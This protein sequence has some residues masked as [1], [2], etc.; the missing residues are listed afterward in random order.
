VQNLTWGGGRSGCALSGSRQVAR[1][2]GYLFSEIFKSM[3]FAMTAPFAPTRHAPNLWHPLG[4]S[5]DRGRA[6][7]PSI[8]TGRMANHVQNY[9]TDRPAP[10]RRAARFGRA[11]S[12]SAARIYSSPPAPGWLPPDGEGS[13]LPRVTA[14]ICTALQAPPP[15]ENRAVPYMCCP[16]GVRCTLAARSRRA[17][18]RAAAMSG[19]HAPLAACERA[20]PPQSVV[21]ARRAGCDVGISPRSGRG[22]AL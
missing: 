5:R 2:P 19:K 13:S 20:W 1:L 16:C 14:A 21:P 17:R 9:C 8:L 11:V 6:P 4:C 12:R 3:P 15:A 22:A 7:A 18:R 10:W